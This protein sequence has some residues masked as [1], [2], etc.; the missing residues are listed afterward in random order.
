MQEGAEREKSCVFVYSCNGK[1]LNWARLLSFL[2]E[3]VGE[4]RETYYRDNYHFGYLQ[5][6]KVDASLKAVEVLSQKELDDVVLCAERCV[7][8]G[9][10]HDNT[11]PST[12]LVPNVILVIKNLPYNMKQATLLHILACFPD[13]KA[14]DVSFHHDSAGLFRGMA[15]VKYAS[16]SDAI[17]VFEH[18][19][20][21]D[22]GGRPIKIEY[23]RKP[24]P[25]DEEHQKIQ[26][27]LLHF[28][29]CFVLFVDC[30]CVLLMCF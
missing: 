3:A 21:I 22:V 11:D 28:K 20:G 6:L 10:G 17:F 15:F 23:K 26:Q 30:L 1:K 19:N 24:D 12:P 4:V 14:D 2:E 16:L 7:R 8:C 5:F 18:L 27:Q 13:H 9:P 29:V 25:L